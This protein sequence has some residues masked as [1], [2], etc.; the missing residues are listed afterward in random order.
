MPLEQNGKRKM[1]MTM[2][3]MKM[4]RVTMPLKVPP[5]ESLPAL[6]RLAEVPLELRVKIHPNAN[7]LKKTF[8]VPWFIFQ[9]EKIFFGSTLEDSLS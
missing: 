2:T 7:S 8:N 3:R 9:K 4:K 1:A 5:E 6:K